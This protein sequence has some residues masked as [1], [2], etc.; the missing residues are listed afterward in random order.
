MTAKGKIYTIQKAHI[1]MYKGCLGEESPKKDESIDNCKYI[2]YAIK[3]Y[4]D[5]KSASGLKI[6]FFIKNYGYAEWP[7]PLERRKR[8]S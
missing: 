7:F 5:V 3:V 1:H 4:E 6:C 8:S 2:L